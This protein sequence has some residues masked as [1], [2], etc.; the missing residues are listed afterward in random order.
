[1]RH[2]H[3]YK[4][5]WGIVKMYI[6]RTIFRKTA[7]RR[8]QEY[9][10]GDYKVAWGE[11][12]HDIIWGRKLRIHR[13]HN[14]L[15]VGRAID[16]RKYTVQQVA[17]YVRSFQPEKVLE[18]GSGIGINILTLAVL[19][20]NAKVLKGIELTEQGIKQSKELLKNPPIKEL[21]YLTELDE[22]TIRERL[23]NRDIE[24]VQGDILKLPW[25]DQTFDFVFTMWVLEQNPRAYMQAFKEARRV[26]QTGGHS[27]FIEEF[28]EAQENF[29]QRLHLRN[30]DV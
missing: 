28:D 1:M 2:F 13:A 5:Y 6:H 14:R 16:S 11:N 21:V 18:L 17:S 10:A 30:V 27:V 8:S 26:L 15:V 7:T 3:V 22:K 12:P 29:F 9:V 19:Y 25:S 20:P 23:M 24:F 4:V